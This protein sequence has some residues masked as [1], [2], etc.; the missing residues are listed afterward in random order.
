[1]LKLKKLEETLKEKEI[2]IDQREQELLNKE[3]EF[4]NK[5]ENLR[6]REEEMHKREKKLEEK[7]RFTLKSIEKI[8]FKENC[9]K[10]NYMTT[11]DNCNL[12]NKFNSN[13]ITNSNYSDIKYKY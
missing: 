8:E 5:E 12:N 7:E 1:M 4:S 10:N 2:S 11:Q 9:L 3:K 6:K 13:L